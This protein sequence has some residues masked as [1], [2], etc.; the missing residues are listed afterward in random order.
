MIAIPDQ[1]ASNG[2]DPVWADDQPSRPVHADGA[3][4]PSKQS[5][6]SLYF[7]KDLRMYL[8]TPGERM[9]SIYGAEGGTRTL[10]P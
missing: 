1:L 2:G 8:G 6:N 10:T 5:G 3:Q 4:Y 7:K 9:G